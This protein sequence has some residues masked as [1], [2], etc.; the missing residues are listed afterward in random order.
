MAL[1]TRLPSIQISPRALC[2][3]ELLATS[4]FSP[5]GCFMGRADYLRVLADGTL[6]LICP[7]AAA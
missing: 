7:V 6:F 2:D 3:L 5:L 4:A 1:A